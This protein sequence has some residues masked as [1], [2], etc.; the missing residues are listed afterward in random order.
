MLLRN[1]I[2]F[3]IRH[4]V[5]LNRNRYLGNCKAVIVKNMT[6]KISFFLKS[7]LKTK[8]CL[9]FANRKIDSF[10]NTFLING[11]FWFIELTF[12]LSCVYWFLVH[13]VFFPSILYFSII[14]SFSILSVYYVFRTL[15]CSTIK[16]LVNQL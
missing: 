11:L 3:S 16:K 8:F 13:C 7:E 5:F 2:N 15:S 1:S 10:V 9:A 6:R 4:I 12:K 14:S